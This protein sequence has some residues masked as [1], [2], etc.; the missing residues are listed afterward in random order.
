MLLHQSLLEFKKDNLLIM[1]LH[2]EVLKLPAAY[3]E[4]RKLLQ[5]FLTLTISTVSTERF[6]FFMKQVK[7]FIRSTT[8]DDRLTHLMWMAIEQRDMAC[9]FEN[10][11]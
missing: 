5:I 2:T 8:G 11:T 1:Y 7:N 10:M 3:S 4:I 9:L 6:L